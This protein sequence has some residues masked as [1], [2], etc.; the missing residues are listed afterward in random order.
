MSMTFL[1]QYLVDVPPHADRYLVRA[2]EPDDHLGI[3]A[4][5]QN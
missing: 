5:A 2:T 4:V 1:E 3:P